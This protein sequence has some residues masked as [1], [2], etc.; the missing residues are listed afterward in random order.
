MGEQQSQCTGGE[1]Q[2]CHLVAVDAEMQQLNA[3]LRVEVQ[4][5]LGVLFGTQVALQAESRPT[6][7]LSERWRVTAEH[8]QDRL[9][10]QLVEEG[11]V[12]LVGKA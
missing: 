1:T 6:K 8:A 12:L 3:V 7:A 5:F 10:S 11:E 9:E 4:V 2:R